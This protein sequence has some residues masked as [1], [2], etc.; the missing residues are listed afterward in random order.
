M[1]SQKFSS[2]SGAQSRP[3]KPKSKIPVRVSCSDSDSEQSTMEESGRRNPPSRRTRLS[4][5]A[6]CQASG[7]HSDPSV[8]H[9]RTR[10]PQ[11][12]GSGNASVPY[13]SMQ[14]GQFEIIN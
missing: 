8:E 2:D 6:S 3:L 14:V 7:S 5:A 9:H 11:A 4:I 13:K 1:W 10:S 12:I